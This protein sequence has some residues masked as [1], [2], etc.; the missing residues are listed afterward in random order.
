VWVGFDDMR[1]LGRGEAGAKTALPIWLD[2]MTKALVGRPTRDFVQPPGV[3]IQRIDKTS[4]L[5]PAAGQETN[6]YD[7]VFL[8][9]TAPT[10]QA[11]AAG[12]ETSA[13]K[14]LLN[15]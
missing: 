2:F 11:A 1:K 3:I 9:D 13:D 5:L 7:E 8:L 14:L 10:E 15:Q 12:E 6:T 4:G